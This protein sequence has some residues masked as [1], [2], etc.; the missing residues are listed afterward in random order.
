MNVEY[1]ENIITSSSSG[2]LPLLKKSLP[3]AIINSVNS[4]HLLLAF[5]MNVVNVDGDKNTAWKCPE[6]TET[7]SSKP[8]LKRTPMLPG[9]LPRPRNREGYGLVKLSIVRERDFSPV[10]L[11]VVLM[12]LLIRL[13]DKTGKIYS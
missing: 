11:S 8:K 9:L 7:Y 5:L 3:N 2:R 6:I 12:T 10:P 1:P 4:S 13:R